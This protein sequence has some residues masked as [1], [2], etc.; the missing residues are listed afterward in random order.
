MKPMMNSFALV[1]CMPK[2]VE[3]ERNALQKRRPGLP[4]SLGYVSCVYCERVLRNAHAQ[5]YSCG[6]LS[7][8]QVSI[9]LDGLYFLPVGSL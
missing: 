2:P 1:E 5:Y 6:T 8:K 7:S 9:N 3:L 4:T